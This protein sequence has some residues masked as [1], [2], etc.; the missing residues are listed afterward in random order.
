[1][2]GC[3]LV[4]NTIFTAPST[5]NFLKICYYDILDIGDLAAIDMKEYSGVT[6]FDSCIGLCDSYNTE[7][8]SK[9]CK[10][11]VWDLEGSDYQDCWLKNSTQTLTSNIATNNPN[12]TVCAIL[13]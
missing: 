12:G 9:V 10:A 7:S 5:S 8:G 3:P 11:V 13:Q 6:T 1:M 4:N 2:A